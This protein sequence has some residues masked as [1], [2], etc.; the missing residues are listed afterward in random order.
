MNLSDPTAVAA[1]AY[2]LIHLVRA[3]RDVI[4]LWITVNHVDPRQQKEVLETARRELTEH[5]AQD[6]DLPT[7]VPGVD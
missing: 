1:A 7:T 5:R 4:I 6:V 2:V 3:A